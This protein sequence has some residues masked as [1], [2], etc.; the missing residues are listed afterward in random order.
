[1]SCATY[2][3]ETSSCSFDDF[4]MNEVVF[5]APST[6][7]S[8]HASSP[9]P[10]SSPA[11]PSAE[12]ITNYILKSNCPMASPLPDPTLSHVPVSLASSFHSISTQLLSQYKV[13]CKSAPSSSSLPTS[14]AI[15]HLSDP[16]HIY[17]LF[18]LASK[19]EYRD[20]CLT[21][22]A[23]HSFAQRLFAKYKI[24]YTSMA[25]Y[26]EILRLRDFYP[27]AFVDSKKAFS[28]KTQNIIAN[29]GAHMRNYLDNR[30]T[31]EC[32]YYLWILANPAPH[33]KKR[34]QIEIR[35]FM[36]LR[37][38]KDFTRHAIYTQIKSIEDAVKLHT[39]P[40]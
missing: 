34:R 27:R 23:I 4:F 19:P 20:I 24:N 15:E 10:V 26:K 32:R 38:T 12:A 30:W 33:I 35:S 37:F 29:I 39:T 21:P 8:G 3:K 14:D 22:D 40:T 18:D 1:M 17:T 2:R 9:P 25:L 6:T 16:S 5:R 13:E 7:K 31:P 36:N 28:E 11:S